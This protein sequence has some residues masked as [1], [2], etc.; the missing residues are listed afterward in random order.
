MLK[1]ASSAAFRGQVLRSSMQ[2]Y[3]RRAYYVDL[4]SQRQPVDKETRRE[5]DFLEFA[6][7]KK[8]SRR[9]SRVLDVA[10]GGGRHIVG[11]A[12]KGY[13]C[14][15]QDYTAERVE[16]AKGRAA[17]YNVSVQLK[18]G[19]AT[20]P[21]YE[22]EFDA[23]EALNVLFLLPSDEDVEKC[24]AGAHRALRPG[25]VLVCNIYNAFGPEIRKLTNHESIVEDRRGRGIRITRINKLE[26][27]DPVLGTGWVHS[28][29][30]VE[31]PDGRHVFR[32]KERFRFFTYW[33]ITRYLENAGFEI[34][35]QYADW[36]TKPVKKP[37]ADQ[38]IFIARK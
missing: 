17:R 20:K 14:T 22:S 24:I 7:R 30:I 6:F 18:R 28:T 5:L 32:D 23:V 25:G 34:I 19:D 26:D 13:Q 1:P 31:A 4:L 36:K 9:V 27:Y 10:C 15:G 16:M 37:L 2:Y 21:G 11:L 12:L 8:A 3:A 35:G 38:I 33:D 29:D